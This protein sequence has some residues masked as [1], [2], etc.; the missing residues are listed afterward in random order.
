MASV[1]EDEA[2]VLVG[3][4]DWAQR[5]RE[6][7]RQREAQ[8]DALQ[9]GPMRPGAD[10]WERRA[11]LF[12]RRV[13]H[14]HDEEQ[15]TFL[16]R[17]LRYVDDRTT[18]VDVGAGVGRLTIPLARRARRVVAVEPAAAMVE[19][20]QEELRSAGVGN[21]E[22]VP[23]TWEVAEVGP[24][25][26]VIC[27]HVLYPIAEAADFLRKI[28]ATATRAAFLQLHVEQ[29]DRPVIE[30]WRAVRGV[31][32][33]P[34]P[35]FL[36]AVNVLAQ[37]GIFAAVEYAAAQRSWRYASPEE[38]YEDLRDRLVIR[39]GTPE[40]ARLAAFVQSRLQPVDG[41]WAFETVP[42]HAG[43]AW[44]EKEA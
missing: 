26:V 44:W 17:V 16:Q 18:V 43:T 42:L 7:V 39:P 38:A 14:R 20:L 3:G 41:E 21:V 15:D 34:Q 33:L 12:R 11:A 5:W 27:A 9:E 6:M 30:A 29:P 28:D 24:A 1:A 13:R 19:L 25:E 32:R 10:F 23:A 8:T 37:L 4:I 35:G 22:I 31:E 36:E 40:A 2:R